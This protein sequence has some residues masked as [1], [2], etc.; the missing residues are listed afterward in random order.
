LVHYST[1]YVF[2]GN[3]D[4]QKVYPNG[5]PENAATDPVNAYGLSKLRGEQA[6]HKASTVHLNIRISWLCS[7]YRKNFMKTMLALANTQ[8]KLTVVSDQLG[9]PTFTFDVVEYTR[10]LIAANKQGTFHMQC[11]G[12]V[13]W[14]DFAVEIFS[15]AG[16]DIA[17]EPVGSD[18]YP[19]RAKRPVFSKLDTTKIKQALDIDS[20]PMK[21]GINRILNALNTTS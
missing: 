16:I 13:S 15:Q 6:I 18:A 5:Y 12:I 10:K 1:D 17:V 4:D 11:D 3:A 19:T 21:K 7:P 8:P 9:A 2:S 14:Y 20:I